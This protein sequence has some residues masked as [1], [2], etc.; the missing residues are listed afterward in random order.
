MLCLIG[1]STKQ[2]KNCSKKAQSFI[3]IK[4]MI[5]RK[6]ALEKLDELIK[7]PNLKKH[8]LAVEA[9]MLEYA[10][11]FGVDDEKER[12]KWAVAG[13]LHDADWEKYPDQHPNIIT[14]YLIEQ[15]APEDLVNAVAAHGFEFGVQPKTLMAKVLRAVDELTGL[16]IAV[17]L[18]K[19]GRLE[20]V[21]VKSVLKKWKDKRFAAGV[22]R[23]DIE[24]GAKEIGVELEKHIQ[25]V[26]QALQKISSDLGL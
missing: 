4:F 8:C 1:Q 17:A 13:L 19:G 21:S 25:I 7:N 6:K 26:L 9:A 2:R 14:N 10:D 23:E 24:K 15:K 22:K 12:E 11:Y 5:S 18:V 20:N 16:I 3:K